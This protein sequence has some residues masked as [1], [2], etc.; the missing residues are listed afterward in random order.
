[1]PRAAA[2]RSADTSHTICA[3][4]RAA[5]VRNASD[6]CDGR[7]NL[8][9]RIDNAAS[10]NHDASDGVAANCTTA[11]TCAHH[12]SYASITATTVAS[13]GSACG[14]RIDHALRRQGV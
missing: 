12:I 8:C 13:A 3:A 11:I 14:K 4:A 7:T 1:V 6:T 5:L 2:A 10:N 9:T